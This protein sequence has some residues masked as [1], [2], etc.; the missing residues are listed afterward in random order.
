[1]RTPRTVLLSLLL[2]AGTAFAK[3]PV[4]V[5]SVDGMDQRYLTDC[6]KLGLKIPNLRKLMREGAVVRGNRRRRF[7][8]S[9]GLRTR[10]SSRVSSRRSTASWPTA[11]PRRTAA[12]GTGRLTP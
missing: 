11:G 5:I 7:R 3:Q 9:R 12:G 2:A 4:L 1:M 10:P 8:R 6:D